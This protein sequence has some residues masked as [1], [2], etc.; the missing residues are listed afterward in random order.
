MSNIATIL[1][2]ALKDKLSEYDKTE[3]LTGFADL[4]SSSHETILRRTVTVLGSLTLGAQEGLTITH[5]SGARSIVLEPEGNAFFGSNVDKPATTS[6]LIRS[7]AGRYNQEDLGAGDVLLGDNSAGK[8]NLF[9][10]ASAGQLKLRGGTTEGIILDTDGTLVVGASTPTIII[11]G[12][13]KVIK[14]SNYSAD[15]A[16]FCLFAASGNAEFNNIV[17]RGSFRTSVFTYENITAIGGNML[18]TKAASENY[19]DVT[20]ADPMIIWVKPDDGKTAALVEDGDVL[21]IKGWNGTEIIDIWLTV[22]ASQYIVGNNSQPCTCDLESGGTGKLIQKGMAV[23][24]YG[25]DTAG[26]LELQAG[27]QSTR[28]RIATHAGAPWTTLTNKVVI[29]NMRG[30]FDTGDNDRYGIGIGDLAG[31]NYLTYNAK[32]ADKFVIVAGGGSVSLD[33]AGFRAWDSAL[34][35]VLIDTDGDAFFGSNLAA[36]ATTALAVFANAQTYN[37]EGIGEGDL[38]LGDNSANKANLLWDKSTGEL[39]FRTGQTAK[40]KID[41]SGRLVTNDNVYLGGDY[42][43]QF[44]GSTGNIRH[45]GWE[46]FDDPNYRWVGEMYGDYGGSGNAVMWMRSLKA[47]GDPWTESMVVLLA[48]N[49]VASTKS[50]I[51]LYSD[52]NIFVYADKLETSTALGHTGDIKAAGDI[53]TIPW[54]DHSG[55]STITGWGS[56]TTKEIFY[57]KV[58]N[59]VHVQYRIEGVGSGTSISFTLPAATCSNNASVRSYHK[60]SRTRDN[61]VWGNGAAYGRMVEGGNTVTFF[62][63]ESSGA[64]GSWTSLLTRVIAGYFVFE[65]G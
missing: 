2:T 26:I 53:Y 25:P 47:T 1:I 38:L 64:A 52:G 34:N 56:Y 40:V 63:Y 61:N 6:L 49:G 45:I 28:L 30:T 22:T 17:A 13:N 11:D 3:L 20:T 15:A 33:S 8:A 35:T 51:D 14:S 43:I 21:R 36:P 12:V 10:D 19:L 41:T 48:D 9:W 39:K 50:R 29:G 60:P 7:E 54:T 44:K 27:E 23:V 58:G 42:G 18:L 16:G 24:N 37:Y 59:L 46:Y 32:V 55:S 62:K 4:E 31:K 57:K 65:A 5:P